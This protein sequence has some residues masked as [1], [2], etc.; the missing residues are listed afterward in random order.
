MIE[1]FY[2][3]CVPAGHIYFQNSAG[4]AP[5]SAASVCEDCMVTT[6]PRVWTVTE[7]IVG[8]TGKKSSEDTVF[9]TGG[10]PLVGRR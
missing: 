4:T 9:F 8:H 3:S 1:I 5:K 10:D 2:G 7:Q 6:T